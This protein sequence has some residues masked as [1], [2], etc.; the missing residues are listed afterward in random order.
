MLAAARALLEQGREVTLQVLAAESGVHLSTL[1]RNWSAEEDIIR[2]AALAASD[3]NLPLPDTG[4]LS[5]D[6]TRFL[7]KLRDYVR[8]PLGRALLSIPLS[9]T[10]NRAD[11]WAGRLRRAAILFERAAR[12]GEIRDNTEWSSVVVAA[13]SPIYFHEM[14]VGTSMTNQQIR[15]HVDL[16]IVACRPVARDS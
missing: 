13:I 15:R 14:V 5:T 9:A 3:S 8:S 7:L 16:I 1:Y 4:R 10:A 11:Y 12:R 2:E 6:L